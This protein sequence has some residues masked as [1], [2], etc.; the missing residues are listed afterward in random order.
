M[1]LGVRDTEMKRDTL[2]LL[3]IT[4]PI[5]QARLFERRERERGREK[6]RDS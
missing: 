4:T 6:E 1:V 2:C 5:A 3:Y